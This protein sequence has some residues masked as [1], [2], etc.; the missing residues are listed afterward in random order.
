MLPQAVHHIPEQPMQIM[1]SKWLFCL[2][3]CL[4]GIALAQSDEIDDSF[5]RPD[6]A[7]EVRLREIL[8]GSASSRGFGKSLGRYYWD[9]DI[10]ATRLND[11]RAI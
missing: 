7:E 4:S 3:G 1:R 8:S 11:K 2:I 6:A 9:R 5:K 10:A